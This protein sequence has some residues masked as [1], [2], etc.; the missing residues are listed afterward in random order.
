MVLTVIFAALNICLG[1]ALAMR[2][3]YGPAGLHEFWNALGSSRVQVMPEPSTMPSPASLSLPD[4]AIQEPSPVSRQETQDIGKEDNIAG[5]TTCEPDGDQAAELLK[6]ISPENWNL[7]EK[8]VE[9]SI[10]RLN[11]AMMKS[12][13]RAIQID[14]RLRACQGHSDPEVIEDCLHSLHD[15][16]LTYLA[17]QKEAA[18]KFSSRISEFGNLSS[19]CEEIEMTNLEQAAQVETTLKNL[20]YM[21]FHSDLEAANLR[22]LEEIKNLHMARHKLRDNQDA[23]F[24]AVAR[25]ENRLSKIEKQLFLD[26]LTGLYNRIGLETT[27]FNWWR[28]GRHQSR[29]MIAVLFDINGFGP[30][31]HKFGP[32]AGDRILYQL[33]QFLQS[34]IGKADLLGRY[35][36]QQFL[37]ML[38]DVNSSAALKNVDLWRQSIEKIIFLY[39]NKPIRITVGA[40]ITIAT[41]NDTYLMLLERLENIIKQAKQTGPNRIFFHNGTQTKPVEPHDINLQETEIIM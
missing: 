18:D 9:T 34:S 12:D 31:N 7:N 2:L 15:D 8:Y 25:Q 6:P 27:L 1:F 36:G 24:L 14:T 32:M 19:M 40:A 30:L 21:D 4:K 5:S 17:E 39:E 20:E 37:A 28:Q 35:S 29:Q 22:L 38:L 3:G 11:I 13:K 16:C 26:T 41:P 23:A 33:A 10:L